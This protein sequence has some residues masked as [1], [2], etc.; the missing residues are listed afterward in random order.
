MCKEILSWDPGC[1]CNGK[2]FQLRNKGMRCYCN[3]C[4]QFYYQEEINRAMATNLKKNN[5]RADRKK[6]G[7]I[8]TS[9]NGINAQVE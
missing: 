2:S 4:L 6:E 9:E 7:D 3:L 8:N 1:P 5:Q